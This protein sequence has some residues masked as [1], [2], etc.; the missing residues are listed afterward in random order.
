MDTT[1]I[2]AAEIAAEPLKAAPMFTPML[3][4]APVAEATRGRELA[5]E[6]DKD[7]FVFAP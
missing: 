5:T 3:F 1:T 4:S 6:P 7:M 2:P